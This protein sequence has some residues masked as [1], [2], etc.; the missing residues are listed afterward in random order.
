MQTEPPADNGISRKQFV[1][2]AAAALAGGCVSGGGAGKAPR[3]VH[4]GPASRYAAEG[5]YS[6]FAPLGFFLVRRQGRL[7]ALLSYCTH[8]RCKLEAEP[9]RSFYCDCHGS[10]F[11]PAG[12]VT[13][14][15]A[16]VDLP[17]LPLI[18]DGAG[19]VVVTVS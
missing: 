8:R 6:D 11:D 10:T 17:E 7:I 18:I 13:K 14:G 16:K 3:S 2:C 5:V 19:G 4:A 9:D 1:F 15:P 12:K